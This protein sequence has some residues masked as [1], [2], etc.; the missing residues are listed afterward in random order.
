MS[1]HIWRNKADANVVA[2]RNPLILFFRYIRRLSALEAIHSAAILKR[3]FLSHSVAP[4]LL[5]GGAYGSETQ[6]LTAIFVPQQMCCSR[7]FW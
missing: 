6:K 2:F 7:N 3:I 4:G 1:T 5:F